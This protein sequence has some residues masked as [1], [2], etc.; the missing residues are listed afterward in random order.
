MRLAFS[1]ALLLL[2]IF[3]F[4]LVWKGGCD[5]ARDPILVPTFTEPVYESEIFTDGMTEYM[6]SRSVRLLV[7]CPTNPDVTRI[8]SGF[9][10][11]DSM[12][13]T[14]RHVID[15][16]VHPL[17]GPVPAFIIVKAYDGT[18]YGAIVDHT[19]FGKEDTARFKVRA[20]VGNGVLMF[21]TNEGNLD[22]IRKERDGLDLP[23]QADLSNR[24]PKIGERVCFVGGA[25]NPALLTQRKCGEVFKV[26]PE[27]GTFWVSVY[28]ARGNSGGPVYDA[29]GKVLGVAIQM[30]GPRSSGDLGM[31]VQRASYLEEPPAEPDAGTPDAGIADAGVPDAP[32]EVEE[33]EPAH[34][35]SEGGDGDGDGDGLGLGL[36]GLPDLPGL[37]GLPSLPGLPGAP[38][39]GL[40]IPM[41]P[42]PGLPGLP[43][44]PGSD[45]PM[46]LGADGEPLLSPRSLQDRTERSAEDAYCP[47]PSMDGR[48]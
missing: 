22:V 35:P 28:V 19:A 11:P 38:N 33:T 27:D 29:T 32:I 41:P 39:L 15:C 30:N 36:P 20:E 9:M 24:E 31:L 48:P 13:H 43:D 25:Q 42:L 14:A 3:A 6:Y 47:H 37:P 1:S 23:L 40:G 45:S 46:P 7:K 34:T 12:I 26:I 8:G 2:C 4:V 17:K 16:G 5:P 10:G 18:Q 21:I 44:L